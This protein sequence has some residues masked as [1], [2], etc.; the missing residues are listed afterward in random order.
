M[1]INYMNNTVIL[2]DKY[3]HDF[4]RVFMMVSLQQ[5]ILSIQ[6]FLTLFGNLT[7]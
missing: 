1:H 4:M 6:R 2:L 5:L 7:L 3:A